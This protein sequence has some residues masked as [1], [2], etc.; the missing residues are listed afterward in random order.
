MHNKLSI[1]IETENLRFSDYYGK[2]VNWTYQRINDRVIRVTCNHPTFIASF[3]SS[4][5]EANRLQDILPVSGNSD[6][7]DHF[8]T[9]MIKS[10]S[11]Q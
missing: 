2:L 11:L 1:M 3:K 8:F 10:Y 7:R 4:Y 9:E 5:F 6:A